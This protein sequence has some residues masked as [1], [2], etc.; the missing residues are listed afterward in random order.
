[1]IWPGTVCGVAVTTCEGVP[2]PSLVMA[3]TRKLMATPLVSP[4]NVYDVMLPTLLEIV[5]QLTPPFVD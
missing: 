5:V 2:T 3:N 1:M 4:V